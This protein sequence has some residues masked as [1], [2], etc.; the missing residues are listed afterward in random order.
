MQGEQSAL[1][2]FATLTQMSKVLV[3]LEKTSRN[4]KIYF[5]LTA[6]PIP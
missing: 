5:V 1:G 6:F 3:V 2:S 4:G